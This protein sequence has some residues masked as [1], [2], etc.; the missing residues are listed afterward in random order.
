MDVRG[1]LRKIRWDIWGGYAFA[2]AMAALATWLK[3]IAQP[4]VIPADVPT[5][6]IVSIVLTASFFGLLSSLLCCA[7]SL[8]AF[9]YYFL[10]PAHNLTL[11][12][13]VLPISL[14]FLFTGI[15]I[16]YISNRLRKKTDEATWEAE[17][18]REH[19]TEL[20]A[21]R[22]HLEELV[23][24][25]T[26]AL[27][28]SYNDLT[29]EI[30]DHKKDEERLSSLIYSIP[31]EVWF[32]DVNKNF[33]LANR[34]A[35]TEFV[36]NSADKIDIEAMA[37]S[38]EV[39]R[40]DGSPRPVDEAP[41][42][43]ALKGETV[44][45]EEEIIRTPATGKLRYRQVS[46]A[47]VRDAKGN[48]I[49]SVS[50]V[51]DITEHKQAEKAL[52]ESEERLKRS[53]EIAHLGSWELDLA[54]S[55]LTWS[56]E[57][58]RIFGIKPQ[59]F[60]ATY[61]AFLEAIHPDDREAVDKAYS[62]SVNE[63]RDSYEIEHRI[64][65]KDNGEIR[66]VHEKCQHVR[67]AGGR[68][69]RS[70]GMVHD[71][72]ERKEI[73]EALQKSY[74]ALETRVQERTAE[75]AEANQSLKIERQ[76]FNDVLEMLPVYVVLL[77]PDYHVP[78]ANRFFEERFGKSG[79]K[80][81]YEYLFHRTEPCEICETYKVLK[82]NAPHHW[83]W[84]GPDDRNYDIYDFPFKDTD[85]SPLIMEMGIDIT[86]Q[87]RAQ[88]LL[89]LEK[90]R[91]LALLRLSE[92]SEATVD[93]TAHFIL[94]QGIA[95]TQSKI[96]FVG[97]L[98]EEES[99]YTL[100]AVSR[101][102]VK[103]CS[104]P[105]DPLQW[106][107]AG[108]GIWADAIR[109][110]KTLFVNDYNKP[111]PSKKGLPPG[112]P[113]VSRLM[114]VPLLDGS[115]IVAVAGMG[116]KA[117]DY[118]ESDEHQIT[119]LLRGMWDHTLEKRAEENLQEAY[120]QL[121][122]RVEDRTRELKETRDYL[123]NLFNHANAPIIVWD[124]DYTITRFNRAF[125]RLTG[126]KAEEVLGTK[127]DILFPGESREESMEH[128]RDATS[129]ERWESVEIPI[130]NKDETV[131]ILLWNSAN[132]YGQDGKTVIATIAQGV[133]ITERKRTEQMKDE[134]I[135][136]VS[137]ELRTPMTVIKGSLRTA[138]SRGISPGDKE[139]LL[140]NAI[141]GADSLSAIL[142]NLLELSRYQVGRLQLHT[143]AV[144]IPAVARAVVERLRARAEDRTFRLEFPDKLPKVQ[145]D[146]MR[147]E[148]ILY[149]LMENAVKYSPGKSVVKVSARREQ[150]MVVT[151]VTDRGAG[152]TP[153]EQGRL[154]ELFE[155]LDSGAGSKGLGLGLVVCKRLVE[156]QGGKIG[157]SSAP[158]KGST[159]YFTLPVFEEA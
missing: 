88:E 134:F 92:M 124:P 136:L 31:D 34:S 93:E 80:R 4:N 87:K 53:Q 135:G 137:H 72:T 94:E 146:P 15:L 117:S 127:L 159:F 76:R 108:A 133:D 90:T 56:D 100:N 55:S 41:P 98:N 78:F 102:V 18:R 74:D 13:D 141:E 24:E 62:G 77:T 97:F 152:I 89:N 43:R 12:I 22:G 39:Y 121:E 30:A 153:E 42:L 19:E 68:I 122:D 139:I 79:G 132:L 85:G 75:L 120:D 148:R 38:L 96:G 26:A 86:E 71:V 140:E 155:R 157:V 52:K 57:V 150:N 44:N 99:V 151:G 21:Y 65:R 128:I 63:G 10:P 119:L 11:S 2:I 3:E 158:G 6:Y 58:Y 17:M 7:L 51:H 82:T 61:D 112:H 110:R 116:N 28:K 66:Y 115:K 1:I 131:R 144:S 138:V 45:N 35:L 54:D 126:R 107:V 113:P 70:L 105:G 20:I 69:I 25:R 37:K 9:V 106:H 129:G 73:E 67:D 64:I 46:A 114:V 16:S 125:E 83:E 123:D 27:E 33:T 84:V 29:E 59:E 101:D 8:L 23:R 95:L 5:L 154:F 109:Q 36:Y 60:E 147:V 130:T 40:T 14:V 103:E 49:G 149:N 91:L 118:D 111:Y 104:V 50:V 32:A 47:P 81:C 145:A 48:I 156:A 143:E 142:E